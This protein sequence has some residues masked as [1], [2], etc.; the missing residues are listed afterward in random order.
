MMYHPTELDEDERAL[1]QALPGNDELSRRRRKR[2]AKNW[3]FPLIV[4]SGSLLIG[5]V[6]ILIVGR[7]L[8]TASLG[9]APLS[10][11][12]K[13]YL[14]SRDRMV[15]LITR[16]DRNPQ[17]LNQNNKTGLI[18]KLILNDATR[19]AEAVN[20]QRSDPKNPA[21]RKHES[22]AYF[23]ASVNGAKRLLRAA[24]G[25]TPT[26][27]WS[28][29]TK[30]KLSPS[31]TMALGLIQMTAVVE[32]QTLPV[33]YNF[34]PA[35]LITDLATHQS[36]TRFNYAKYLASQNLNDPA[37]ELQQVNEFQQQLTPPITPPKQQPP[38]VK[39]KPSSKPKTP[40]KP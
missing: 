7:T 12:R 14:E 22:V 29:G 4:C 21:Y 20:Q 16:Y 34:S 30:E 6:L 18:Q 31:Q 23:L 25:E 3:K 9:D 2:R 37:A 36:E 10:E 27:V 39:P 40:S 28:D 17:V 38:P 8:Q 5:A 11:T 26:L 24:N 19:I 35:E 15:E 1:E 13:N 32:A 33:R